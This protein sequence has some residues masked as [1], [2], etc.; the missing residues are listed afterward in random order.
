MNIDEAQVVKAIY[1]LEQHDRELSDLKANIKDLQEKTQLLTELACAIKT[2]TENIKD[3]KETVMDIK[4]EQTN[5]KDEITDLKQLPSQNKA[6]AYDKVIIGIAAALGGG[7]LTYLLKVL[8][9]TI[10]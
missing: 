8:F 10:F 6:K 3:V 4:S 7:I 9:P 2:L 5:M 1:H